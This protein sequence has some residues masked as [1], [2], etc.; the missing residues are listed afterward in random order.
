LAQAFG[1]LVGADRL[2]GAATGKQPRGGV[3][4][5]QDQFRSDQGADLHWGTKAA[6]GISQGL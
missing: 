1:A 5:G 4:C 6:D 3:M 2:A